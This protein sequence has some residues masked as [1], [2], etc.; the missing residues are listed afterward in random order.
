MTVKKPANV[1]DQDIVD[2]Q[3]VIDR[4]LDEP[5]NSSSLICRIRFAELCRSFLERDC[6]HGRD[7]DDPIDY[8]SAMDIDSKFRIFL[9]QLPDFF[10]IDADDLQGVSPSS[11]HRKHSITMQRFTL[12]LIINRHLCKL[13]LPY[14]VK[15]SF[16]PAYAYSHD[17]CLMA[18]RTIV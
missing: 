12:H 4:P 17:A 9:Q 6:T 10:S 13:H 15:G 7:L 11:P 8:E 18:A 3:P 5:T 2:G 14:L 16:E 1:D